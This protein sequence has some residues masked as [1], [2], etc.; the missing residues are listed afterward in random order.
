MRH[1][2]YYFKIFIT[3]Y[4][5]FY[6]QKTVNE[7][8]I[9]KIIKLIEKCEIVI[10]C[11]SASFEYEKICQFEIV[12]AN[13]I[14]KLV[15]PLNIQAKYKPDYWVEE[16]FPRN[17]IIDCRLNTMNRDI[18]IFTREISIMLNMKKAKK[19]LTITYK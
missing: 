12:Y 3:A 17:R 10:A 9:E 1:V 5:H 14:G 8:D 4:F 11:L 15:M 18:R 13:R 6:S 19:E 7:L 16:V 2:I